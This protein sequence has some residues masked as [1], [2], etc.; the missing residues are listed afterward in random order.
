[1]TTPMKTLLQTM[2]QVGTVEWIGCSPAR[3]API[4]IVDR[5]WIREHTGLDG[6]HHAAKNTTG[7]NKR[8]V[9]L[10]QAEHL[11]AIASMAGLES[12]R[13]EALRRNLMV[14]GINLLAL[15]GRRFTVGDAVLEYTGTCDPCSRMEATLGPGGWNAMRMQGGITARVLSGA[16]VELGSEVRA[17]PL[18]DDDVAAAGE[19]LT[20]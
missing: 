16:E 8:Q 18:P 4:Q 5:V 11:P 10:I 19:G 17:L 20:V 14:R 2:P 7:R 9:T 3:K 15:K 12:V 1:M 6:D 13:P